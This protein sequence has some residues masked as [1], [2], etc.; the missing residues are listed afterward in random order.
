MDFSEL[1]FRQLRQLSHVNLHRLDATATDNQLVGQG[2][3]VEDPSRSPWQGGGP[4]TLAPFA[5]TTSSKAS[6]RGEQFHGF[7]KSEGISYAAT[8]P[9]EAS[10]RVPIRPRLT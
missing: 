9:Y 3:L 6:E 1:I 10:W 5:T 2:G 8:V 4:E 7:T